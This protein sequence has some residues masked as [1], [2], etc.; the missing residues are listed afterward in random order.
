MEI[1]N[2]RGIDSGA[3]IFS[4]PLTKQSWIGTL[5][6]AGGPNSPASRNVIGGMYGSIDDGGGGA[7][8]SAGAGSQVPNM[9]A[10]LATDAMPLT[11]WEQRERGIVLRTSSQDTH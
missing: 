6:G 9:Y 3:D 1:F 7:G 4:R 10:A 11:M 2:S 8:S 5:G